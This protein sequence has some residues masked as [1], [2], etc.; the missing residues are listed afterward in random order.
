MNRRGPSYA[1]RPT[2]CERR[3]TP[4]I[5]TEGRRRFLWVVHIPILTVDL[6]KP[7]ILLPH[8]NCSPAPVSIYRKVPPTCQSA[9]SSSHFDSAMQR[10]TREEYFR[11]QLEL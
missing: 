4:S 2:F 6:T 5:S 10:K 1:I 9:A 8:L 11:R 3:S 7:A